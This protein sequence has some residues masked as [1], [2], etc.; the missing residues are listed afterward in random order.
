MSFQTLVGLEGRIKTQ[1]RRCKRLFFSDGF[2]I[3]YSSFREV[4][5][6]PARMVTVVLMGRSMDIGEFAVAWFG[7]RK[8]DYYLQYEQLR[9][10]GCK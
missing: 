6:D 2:L 7:L 5:L 4:A 9:R 3:N 8:P 10:K 1:E